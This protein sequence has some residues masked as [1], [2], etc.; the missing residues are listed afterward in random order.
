LQQSSAQGAK[1]RT[2]EHSPEGEAD[3][4]EVL[5]AVQSSERWYGTSPRTASGRIAR[6]IRM[7]IYSEKELVDLSVA[8]HKIDPFDN[9]RA[10]CIK[11]V[12]CYSKMLED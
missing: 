5:A 2:R 10:E 11:M 8:I 4:R 1:G 6:G 3:H 9:G 12:I 7:I